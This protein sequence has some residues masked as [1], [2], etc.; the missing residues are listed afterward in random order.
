[1]YVRARCSGSDAIRR[2]ARARGAGRHGARCGG[3][4]GRAA[5]RAG[6]AAARGGGAYDDQVTQR[7]FIV[8]GGASAKWS[9]RRRTAA[10]ARRARGRPRRRRRA[11]PHR[12]PLAPPSCAGRRA[13]WTHASRARRAAAAASASAAAS[14]AARRSQYF[15]S[16]APRG[17]VGGALLRGR[18]GAQ[19]RGLGAHF[20]RVPKLLDLGTHLRRHRLRVAEDGERR[21]VG[22]QQ[23][24][25]LLE[26]R[27][28]HL[29]RRARR[30]PRERLR[31]VGR[32]PAAPRDRREQ[33]LDRGARA[34]S[35]WLRR[36]ATRACGTSR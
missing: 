12:S 34:A 4:G 24:E 14:S 13:G 33:R 25:Q 23:G 19:A 15:S 36:R 27:A 17:V 1:M 20:I 28:P 22:L 31:L 32:R 30:A 9:S 26:L 2:I 16:L 7:S 11:P 3:R 35:A 6:A 5:R 21:R 8:G 29:R 18:L 10:S